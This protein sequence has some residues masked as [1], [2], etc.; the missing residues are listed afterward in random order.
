MNTFIALFRGINVGG[1]RSL[2]MKDL[3]AIL[4]CLGLKNVKTYL[5]SGNAVIQSISNDSCQLSHDI[6]QAI[7]ESH[8]FTPGVFV[9][10]V[11]ELRSAIASNPFPE[12]ED[13]PTSLH[14]LFLK[15]RPKRPDLA[16]LESLRSVSEKFELSDTVFYLHAPD[17]IGRSKLAANVEKSLGVVA[18]GRNWRSVN[19]V[20]SLALEVAE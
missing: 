17:G 7:Y 20:M 18:T 19:A 16:K 9:L 2:K 8:Q 14:V 1:H 5:Q 11:E 12:G 10:S 3:R 6:G 4:E 15:S 13:H